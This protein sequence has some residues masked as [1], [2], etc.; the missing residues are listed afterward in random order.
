MDGQIV[1][2]DS[3]ELR[4]DAEFISSMGTTFQ[5]QYEELF[6]EMDANISGAAKDG[7]AWWGPQAELFL[8][9]FNEKKAVFENAYKNINS[10]ANNLEQQADA[11]DAFERV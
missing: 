3:G 10:M 7:I 8:N 6:Q 11:W 4:Q 1:S 5:K 9:T 2:Q